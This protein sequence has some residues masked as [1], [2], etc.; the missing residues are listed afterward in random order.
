MALT[1]LPRLAL[2]ASQRLLSRQMS[3]RSFYNS[4]DPISPV[5]EDSN[6]KY[7]SIRF[8]CTISGQEQV[9]Q[10]KSHHFKYGGNPKYADDRF[11]IDA[12]KSQAEEP[13]LSPVLTELY[14]L[15]SHDVPVLRPTFFKEVSD[16]FA[17]R[18]P[19]EAFFYMRGLREISQVQSLLFGISPGFLTTCPREAGQY[20]NKFSAVV[21]FYAKFNENVTSD[22]E[23]GKM[24]YREGE[25]VMLDGLR[26]GGMHRGEGEFT[27]I[28]SLSTNYG[29]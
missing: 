12:V 4:V 9:M 6:K 28:S 2:T 23:H 20:S 29:C 15:E 26:L 21:I 1:T 10:V 7:M 13:P 14:E 11:L 25:G 19:D 5:L 22:N 18:Q 27:N 3:S 16:C 8:F 24:E 17:P